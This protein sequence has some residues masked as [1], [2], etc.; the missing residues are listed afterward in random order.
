M[1]ETIYKPKGPAG[2]Y[3]EW[4]VSGPYRGCGHRCLYCYVPNVL[5]MPR[6][7]FDQ[8]AVERPTWEAKFLRA[9][10]RDAERLA[11]GSSEAPQVLL[12]FTTDPYHP[13]DT[14][15]TRVVLQLLREKGLRFCVLTKG[16]TRALRDLDLYR[17]GLD[18]FACTLTGVDASFSRKWE[19]DAALPQDRLTA[20]R[21]FHEAGIRTWVSLEPVLDPDQ[22]LAA[23]EASAPFVDLY[24]VGKLNHVKNATDWRAFSERCLAMF[25][26]LEKA[27][28]VKKDLKPYW[29]EVRY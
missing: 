16:G 21:T 4:A 26:K 14:R 20:L 15:L 19:P 8:G 17:R 6:E 27:F 28:Y 11:A 12:S 18:D 25:R 9:L 5:R 29:P 7:V 2:E 22:T 23:I 3:A 24:K 10:G 1:S 13:G